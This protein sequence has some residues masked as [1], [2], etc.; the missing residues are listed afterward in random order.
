MAWVGRDL[1]C[2]EVTLGP[3]QHRAGLAM[4]GAPQQPPELRLVTPQ[5]NESLFSFLSKK[6]MSMSSAAVQI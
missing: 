4:S 5:D 1:R 3:G 6:C 2:R